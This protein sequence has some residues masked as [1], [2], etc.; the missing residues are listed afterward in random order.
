M[1]RDKLADYI[2]AYDGAL[3]PDECQ[4]LIQRFE[5]SPH[6]HEQL[7]V[8]GAYSFT[9]VSLSRH[10]P[11]AEKQI[12][13]IFMKAI[14]QYRLS[15]DVGPYWPDRPASEEIRLKRYLP[16]GRDSFPHHVDV[17]DQSNSG[18]FITAILYLNAPGGGETVFSGL[19]VTVPPIPGR[20]VI[21]P[22]LWLFPHAGMPPVHTPKYILHGYLW[23]PPATTAPAS[24]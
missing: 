11:D 24:P 5:A 21:F 15:L 16:G 10:W 14:G 23:Y 8:E 20:L 4:A 17:M 18:R 7:Q 1:A 13:A 22:P 2:V 6:Q 12:G 3:S 9:Q 19:G